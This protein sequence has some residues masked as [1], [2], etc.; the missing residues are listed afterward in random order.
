MERD[1]SFLVDEICEKMLTLADKVQVEALLFPVPATTPRRPE[2]TGSCDDHAKAVPQALL[3]QRVADAGGPTSDQ[4]QGLGSSNCS[5]LEM[6]T[7][8]GDWRRHCPR[9]CCS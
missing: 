4:C 8:G 3:R 2:A 9:R 5:T 1:G 6:A 7:P